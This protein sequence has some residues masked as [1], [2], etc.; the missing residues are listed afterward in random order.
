MKKLLI[1]FILM[2]LPMVASAYD[3][4]IDGIYYN[5]NTTDKTATVT[6]LYYNSVNN[7]SAY[8]GAVVIPEKVTYNGVTYSVTSIEDFAFW[9]CRGLTSITIPNSV[10]FIGD[11]AFYGCNG[12]TSV[13]IPNS[14]TSIG[15]GAFYG[16][17][18]YNSQPN[19][20][21]YIDDWLIG[22]K[23][24][25]LT[26]EIIIK[27]ETKGIAD[28]AFSGC[29][30]LTSV[31]IPNSVT[32]IG[33]SAF[34]GC[35]GLPSVTIPNSVTIIG[36]SAFSGCS[37]LPSVTIPNSVTSIG[38]SAF[39]NCSGLTSITIGNSVTSIG[40]YAFNGCSGLTS[41]TIP[42]SVTS[43]GY[44]AFWNCSGLT[45][46]TIGNSVTSIGGEAFSGCSDLTSVNIS[47]LDA[48][49][50]ISFN[51]Y[52]A[53]PLYYAKHL[54]IGNEEVTNANIPNS[55]T[56]IEGYAFYNCSGLTSVTIPNSVTS[57]GSNAF[58]GCTSI[59][60]VKSYIA[61]PFNIS[62]FSDETYR[63]GTLYVP[64]GTK[65][66]YIRFDGWREFL[67]I[68]EMEEEDPALPKCDT[69]SILVQNGKIKFQCNT[70]DAE[71]TSTLTSSETFTGSEVVLGNEITYT[72]KVYA[73]APGFNKSETATATFTFSKSDLNGDGVIDV[74]DIMAI[75]NI[76]AQ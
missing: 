32:I 13:T 7:Q 9:Y 74:G 51:N 53:N 21:L 47:N 12:L 60:T 25:N 35:S 28:S 62:R 11:R 61:E 44:G 22:Y 16:T 30:G 42:N 71:F 2:L 75:I 57:I 4:Q 72:I 18:W 56:S 64:A 24:D 34:S 46:V 1:S 33:N 45:S 17:G 37:G 50:K 5:F 48:W 3:A 76:M 65:D 68:E 15:S 19:G 10:T 54:F 29:S 27:N 20:I 31:T 23:G 63:N 41:V 58:G 8:S 69:P 59:M 66:L 73:T 40:S 14:V 39:S 49:C 43:I 52:N 67:K 36:N 26:G 6:F 70:P 55:V 38:G